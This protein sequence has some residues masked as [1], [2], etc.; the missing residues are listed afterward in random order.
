MTGRDDHLLKSGFLLNYMFLAGFLIVSLFAALLIQIGSSERFIGQFMLTFVV[1]SY[2]FIGILAKTMGMNTF[3]FGDRQ[4]TRSG[5]SQSVASGVISAS[6]FIILAG[7]FY[8]SGITAFSVYWGWL[9][10]IGLMVFMFSAYVS[11][12]QQVTLP[13]LL[14]NKQKS[15]FLN[16]IS[17]VA[18]LACCGLLA[19]LQLE[20]VAWLGVRFFSVTRE[21]AIV[22]A[23]VA[24][25]FC[26]LCGGIQSVSLVRQI[27]YPVI[28]LCF[29]AP[30]V[31][32]TWRVTGLPIPQLAFGFGAL[33]PLALFDQ[34]L[35]NTELAAPAD[36]FNI[37]R[38]AAG[39]DI[40]AYVSAFVC[41]A[42][43]V[44]AM[45]HL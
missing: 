2:I 19:L 15:H 3:E 41:I 43:G 12:S 10:G 29:L 35:A 34:Q 39:P 24:I 22:C 33:E 5:I 4:G 17:M 9:G 20:M 23:C 26:V 28:L 7:Q 38:D 16:L 37:A 21:A 6:L 14:R 31:W 27:S 11:R 44:A 30:L 45:P 13:G 8:A 32:I 40:F 1:S 18:T 25:G 42:C 36:L